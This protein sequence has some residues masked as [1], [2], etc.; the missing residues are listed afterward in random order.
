MRGVIAAGH[1]L[2]V[3]A[4][5]VVLREGGKAFDAIVA[6]HFAACVAEPILTSLGG[7]GFL[8]AK[9]ASGQPLVFD[10]FVHTPYEKRTPEALDA[11]EVAIDFGPARQSFHIGRG[12][13]ATPGV[14]KGVFEAHR[15][16]CTMPMRELCAPAIRY[17]R[18][19][20]RMNALLAYIAG[21]VHPIYTESPAARAI[22]GGSGPHARLLEGDIIRQPALAET[23]EALAIEG[24]DLFYRGEIA[25]LIARDGEQGGG[26]LTRADLERYA[27]ELREPLITEYRDVTIMTNPPPSSGGILI[28]FA[29]KL[30]DGARLG[31]HTFGSIE[32][33][34]LLAKV[35]RATSSARVEAL[36][37]DGYL[38]P[39]KLLDAHYLARYRQQVIGRPRATRGTTHIS[40]IDGKGNVA[41]MS[42]SNGEGC[43]EIV[44]GTGIML[45]NMLGE[46]DLS[47]HGLKNWRPGL[48]MSSMMAPSLV[49]R[50]R[51]EVIAT[52][53][54][55]SNRIRTAILQ[56]LINLVDYD[57]DVE[58]AVRSPRIHMEGDKLSLEGGLA[59]EKLEALLAAFPEHETW[60]ELN[61]FFGG[62]HTVMRAESGFR[63]AGDPRRGGVSRIVP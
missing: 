53:S 22:Y 32:H 46:D 13:S 29:L 35:M 47:P 60:P 55:G 21:V 5:E 14:V 17:A 49:L 16:L 43:G 57:M 2:T 34:R 8:L 44:P 24:D 52:G 51:G 11:R 63:G 33:L 41:S 50:P 59:I 48:R 37:P 31:A 42:L 61:L 9:P 18:E 40:V 1:E 3:H 20:V 26:L 58:P 45:N 23:L 19:G 25:H 36:Q 10:F 12:T 38:D 30:L 28:A 4:A 39:R 27:V 6:A 54:G 62:A 56:V 7:G 15:R